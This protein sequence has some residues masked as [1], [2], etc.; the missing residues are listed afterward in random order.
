MS[1]DPDYSKIFGFPDN[2]GA[3][4]P[5]CSIISN[6]T[7]ELY[8]RPSTAQQVEGR[9]KSNLA[10][11]RY[12]SMLAVGTSDGLIKLFNLKGYEQEID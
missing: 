8:K 7:N 3:I 2:S 10:C 6:S 4:D 1:L 12:Q 11:D 9:I 5:D